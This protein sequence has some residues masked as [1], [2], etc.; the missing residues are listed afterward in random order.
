MLSEFEV[1]NFKNF[2]EPF[3]LS[4]NK[5]KYYTFNPECIENGTVKKALIY[6]Y[7]ACGKSNL[8]LAVLDIVAHVTDFDSQHPGY[9]YFLSAKSSEFKNIHG[10][11]DEARFKYVFKFDDNIVE[12]EYIKESHEVVLAEHLK[13]NGILYVSFDRRQSPEATILLKGADT[14]KTEITNENLSIIKYIDKNAMLD[15]DDTNAVFYKFIKF[16]EGML[17][18]RSLETNTYLGFESGTKSISEDIIKRGNLN[19]F[20]SFLNEVGVECR[21]IEGENHGKPTIMFDFGNKRIPFFSIASTGTQSLALFYYWYQKL[22]PLEKVTFVYIDEFD[23]F[24][25]HDLAKAVIARMK[26]IPAQVVMTTHNTSVMTNDLL[27]PD[28]YFL[29]QNDSIDSLSE[30]TPKEIRVAHNIEKMYR[31]RK[32]SV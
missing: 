9:D 7:N 21:L 32:F 26:E 31:A 25:H 10:L 14:L 18:F 20:Q 11:D 22:K 24:Y 8:G 2:K 6:G 29:M 3:K 19:D 13:I 28:C 17:L 15:L 16:V 5:T 1:T 4:F 27:R 23:A 12:Y 30:C